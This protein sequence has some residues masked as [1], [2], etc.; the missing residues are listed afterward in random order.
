MT[1][2]LNNNIE[3]LTLSPSSPSNPRLVKLV[4]AQKKEI[5]VLKDK[6]GLARADLMAAKMSPTGLMIREFDKFTNEAS[7]KAQADT[8]GLKKVALVTE[9]IRVTLHEPP[10]VVLHSITR[11]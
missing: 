9:N 6:L 10:N 11:K 2:S 7:K 1:T 3:C 4:A 8:H 5:E